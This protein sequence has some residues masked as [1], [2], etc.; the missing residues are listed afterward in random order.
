MAEHLTTALQG[1][2]PRLASG[3]LVLL[4]TLVIAAI[5]R[6]GVEHWIRRADPEAAVFISK[7]LFVA[8]VI[9]GGLLALGRLGVHIAALA[10]LAGAFGLAASLSLQDVAKNIV[11][12]LYLLIER[13]F[14]MGDQITVSSFT[15]RVAVVS[16]RTTTLDAED[17]QQVLVPNTM[18]MSQVVLKK[19]KT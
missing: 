4:L 16:L 2:L 12:G 17:G 11:A 8:L 15:G 7:A 5:V 19:A 1:Y 3:A 9:A 14:Q 10:T 18:I 6:K 13:P